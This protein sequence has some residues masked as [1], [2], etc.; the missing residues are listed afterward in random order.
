[1]TTSIDPAPDVHAVGVDLADCPVLE[2]NFQA[3]GITPSGIGDDLG[4]LRVRF[5]LHDAVY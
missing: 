5:T 4:V 3:I 2:N 1:M